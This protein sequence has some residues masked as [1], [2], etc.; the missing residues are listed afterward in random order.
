M[1]GM[2]S[3]M[4]FL[5]LNDPIRT[6]MYYARQGIITGEMHYVATR[7]HVTGD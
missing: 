3:E 5:C 2:R 1:S 7:E 4:D 6:Q